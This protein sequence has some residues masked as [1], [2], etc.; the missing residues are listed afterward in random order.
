MP[1]FDD[2]LNERDVDLLYEYIIRGRHN[3]AVEGAHW[4]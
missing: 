3:K 4:Y 2:Q 1:R